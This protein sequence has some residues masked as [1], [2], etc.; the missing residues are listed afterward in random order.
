MGITAFRDTN[1]R[2]FGLAD[3]I[4]TVEEGKRADLIVVDGQ[5]LDDVAVLQDA[6]RVLVVMRDGTVQKRLPV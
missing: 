4:G 3:Q 5:P 1:A 2:L 6:S